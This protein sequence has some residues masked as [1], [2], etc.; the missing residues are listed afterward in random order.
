MFWVFIA[1]LIG[2]KILSRFG[3]IFLI[4]LFIALVVIVG[5]LNA[6]IDAFFGIYR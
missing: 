3:L 6:R 1:G 2:G 4:I 5:I